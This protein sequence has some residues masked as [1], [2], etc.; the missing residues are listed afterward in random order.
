MK[1]ELLEV[2][3]IESELKDILNNYNIDRI[4]TIANLKTTTTDISRIITVDEELDLEEGQIVSNLGNSWTDINDDNLDKVFTPVVDREIEYIFFAENVSGYKVQYFDY[5]DLFN[6]YYIDEDMT[7]DD[8]DDLAEKISENEVYVNFM[9]LIGSSGEMKKE[10]EML[11]SNEQKFKIK[12]INDGREDVG[13][14]EI[15]LETL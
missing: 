12:E 5:D 7:E 4:E 10:C 3:K 15:I 14:I 1:K 11:V 8:A 13:Y 6:K 2:K 9:N